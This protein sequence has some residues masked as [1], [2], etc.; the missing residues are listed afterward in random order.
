MNNRLGENWILLRGLARESAHWGDFVPLLQATFPDAQITTLDLPG[1]G[2]FYQD[3]SPCTIKAIAET[4]RSHALDLGLL[5]RPVTVLALSLG[6][7]VT[8]EWMQNYPEDICGATLMSTSFAGLSPFYQRLRWQSYGKFLALLTQSD[9]R[10]RELSI[11]QLVN[12]RRELD[13]RIVQ[14]WEKIQI[15]RPVSIKNTLN[16]ILAAA[17]YRSGQ[18]KPKPPVL[19]LNAKGDRLVSPSCSEAIHK[20]WH[21]ELHSHPWAGHDLTVDDGA[22]VALQL[23]DWVLSNCT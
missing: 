8:W 17:T 13:E 3:E 1:M 15:E 18:V 23:K 7:M 19:L 14:D 16:Q 22:W 10:K 9:L 6:A 21:L 20:K 2:R 11:L 5:Q 12:N 4:V